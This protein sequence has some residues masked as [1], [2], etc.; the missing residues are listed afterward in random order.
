MNNLALDPP[1]YNETQLDPIMGMTTITPTM[2]ISANNDGLTVGSDI[3]ITGTTTVCN[4]TDTTLQQCESQLCLVASRVNNS[5]E[6]SVCCAWDTPV[7]MPSADDAKEL[8]TDDIIAVWLTIRQS[9][10]IFQS[11][12]LS[13]GNVI[14]V[15]SRSSNSMFNGSYILMWLF[16]TLVSSKYYYL[17]CV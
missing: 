17:F 14:S 11:G 5:D 13:S 6:Y 12:L 7:T 3:D 8:D 2:A 10:I 9:E 16:G 4:L 1:P 15:E